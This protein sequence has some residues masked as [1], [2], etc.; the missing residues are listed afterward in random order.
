MFSNLKGLFPSPAW[1]SLELKENDLKKALATYFEE[2]L[3]IIPLTP[4]RPR[5]GPASNEQ[6]PHHS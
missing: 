1:N 6:H 2:S 4:K 5:S 3:G